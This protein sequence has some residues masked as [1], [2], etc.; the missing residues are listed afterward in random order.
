MQQSHTAAS[1]YAV[2]LAV[3]Q[4]ICWRKSAQLHSRQWRYAGLRAVEL[5]QIYTGVL[6]SSV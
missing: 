2:K 4:V 5:P 6:G 1:K 3:G